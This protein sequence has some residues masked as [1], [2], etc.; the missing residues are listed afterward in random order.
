MR[1]RPARGAHR[2]PRGP[3]TRIGPALAAGTAAIF[4]ATPLFGGTVV[5]GE[6]LALPFVLAGLA[7]ALAASTAQSDVGALGL[8]MLAGAAGMLA[9]MTKQSEIDVFVALLALVAVTR[10]TGCS[11]AW[12]P[13]PA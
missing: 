3:Q 5:H 12:S 6:L 10:A 2:P 13:V 7:A 9:L 11:P 1:R 8:A 4:T